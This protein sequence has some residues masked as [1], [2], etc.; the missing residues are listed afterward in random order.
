MKFKFL[1]IHEGVKNINLIF[2][3][4]HAALIND[5]TLMSDV[6]ILIR[7]NNLNI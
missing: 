7:C 3:H 6:A 4:L 5:K 1:V 2:T